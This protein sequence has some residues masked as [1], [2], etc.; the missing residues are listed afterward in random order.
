MTIPFRP[1][2]DRVLLRRVEVEA[3][4]DGFTV[5]EKYRQHSNLGE[6]L[7]VGDGVV[8]GKEWKP[9]TDFIKVGDI[10]LYGEYTAEALERDGEQYWIVRIQD[11]R[12]VARLVPPPIFGSGAG[13]LD[14][15]DD[16]CSRNKWLRVHNSQVFVTGQII[17]IHAKANFQFR[18]YATITDVDAQSAI[19]LAEIPPDTQIGDYVVATRKN[20]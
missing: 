14:S 5:P 19:Y 1:I 20:A 8:L 16:M 7:A 10:C 9:L 13:I 2:L 11:I 15:I 18:G 12:G 3:S 17:G 4:P 6:V